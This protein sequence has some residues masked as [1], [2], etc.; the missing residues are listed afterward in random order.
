MQFSKYFQEWLYGKNG[1]YSNYKTIGKDG[2][3]FTAVST[4][5]FFGGS[6]ANHI[7]KIIES[8]FLPINT[9]IIE[10]GAHKGYLLS[11]IIQFIFTIKPELLK[12][13]NFAIVEPFGKLREI[14]QNYFKI[15][16]GDEINLQH[17]N[18]LNELSLDNAFIIANEIFDAFPCELIK[19]EKMLYIDKNLNREF[20]E[21]DNYCE[22]IVRK[23][24]IKT[25]EITKGFEEFGENLKKGIKKFEFVTFDYGENYPRNDFSIRVY[26]QH[27]TLPF[28]DEKMMIK[29]YFKTSDITYDVNF[30]HLI[31]SF[32]SI[33]INC[34]DYKTQLSALV[35]FGLMDLLEILKNKV[36]EKIY[37]REVNKIKTLIDPTM[38]GERFKMVSFRK[39]YL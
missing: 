33:G 7:I 2:D 20:R 37:L 14:Q 16:F 35:N 19:D 1:Y 12:T 5:S 32:E 4:S 31:D 6:I 11:D 27:Q 36:D 10:I 15:S 17:Y 23:Y 21:L 24:K 26:K 13:L 22:N 3:F 39:N 29:D 8:N 28:F 38:M 9:T 34:N 25:G 18:N 30:K